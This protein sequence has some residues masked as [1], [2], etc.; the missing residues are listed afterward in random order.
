M[1]FLGIIICFFSVIFIIAG[2]IGGGFWSWVACL[3]GGIGLAIGSG[4]VKL[5]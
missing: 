3:G 2:L 1:K 4:L 5:A